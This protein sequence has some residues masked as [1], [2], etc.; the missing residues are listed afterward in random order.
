MLSSLPIRLYMLC[1]REKELREPG[2]H[3]RYVG[4]AL[5][6][7]CRGFCTCGRVQTFHA[8]H[9]KES[10]APSIIVTP[11]TVLGRQLSKV[12]RVEALKDCETVQG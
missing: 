9:G 3:R 7:W 11:Y 8:S 1:L 12:V 2:E 6:K 5:T 10:I 4:L